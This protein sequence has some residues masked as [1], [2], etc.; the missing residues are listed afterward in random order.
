MSGAAPRRRPADS[1]KAIGSP[2]LDEIDNSSG[3]FEYIRT[4][5]EYGAYLE[6]VHRSPG[7]APTMMLPAPIVLSVAQL[8]GMRWSKSPA[9][10][11]KRLSDA[12]ANCRAL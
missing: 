7:V 9:V 12:A 5:P 4:G 2:A 1:V 6:I 8:P 10:P 11:N 3:G